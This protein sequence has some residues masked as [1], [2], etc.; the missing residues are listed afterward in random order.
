MVIGQYAT[1]DITLRWLEMAIIIIAYWLVLL[2]SWLLGDEMAALLVTPLGYWPHIIV[3]LYGWLAIAD[4]C[5]I[6]GRHIQA[7]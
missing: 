3:A 5:D 7:R 2:P 4:T 6:I 1:V